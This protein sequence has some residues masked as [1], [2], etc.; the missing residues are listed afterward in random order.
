[1]LRNK[2][3][4]IVAIALVLV[5]SGGGYYYYNNVYLQA[6]EPIGEPTLATFV[7]SRGD[8]VIT[9]D[10]SGTLVPA[11]EMALGF[12]SGGVLAEVLVEVGDNV[13]AGQVLARLDDAE[14]QSQVDQAKISLRQAELNLAEL[15]QEVDPAGLASAQ[16]S[17]ASAKAE[18]TKLTS[19]PADQDLLAA[20]E[21]V[22]SAQEAL[23]DLLA[24]PDS[25]QVEIA[26]ADLTLAEINLRTAQA[27]YDKVAWKDNV[28]STK[29]AAD[30]WQATTN[31]DRAKA[32]HDEVRAGPAAD[33][34]SDARS[35]VAQAQAQLDAL[36]ED[37]DPN[38]IVAAEAKV[39]QAQAQLDDLLAGASAKDLE[40]AELNVAQAQLN[41]ESAQ[42]GLEDTL[43]VAPAPGTVVAA[44]AQ[45]GESVGTSAF[46]T[47]ADLEEPQVLFWVEES[48]LMSVAPGNRVNIVFEA[49]PDY[50]FPG[51]ILSVDPALVTVDGTS[52]VQS[53]A[54]V[55]VSHQRGSAPPVRLLSGMNAEVEIVAGQALN[56]VLVPIQALRDLGP[57]QYAV[58]VVQSNGELELRPVAVGLKD[59]VHAEILS[60][61]EPGQVIST[62]TVES[63]DTSTTPATSD[64]QPPPGIMRL[65]GGG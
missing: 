40:T 2:L 11:S 38:E 14:A 19:P 57:E 39:A 53:W 8:L 25:E 22:K 35:R 7:V 15:A 17:L 5:A 56:A 10:G 44:E 29:E 3:F 33:E 60:G 63:T 46:I 9:A 59:F 12:R 4:W 32:E 62:G 26:K 28:G 51:E 21:N 61:L 58:F 20:Q 43:L 23:D 47:L 24:G 42:R 30:L 31:Y 6:Q 55:D 45:R 64:E 27:A 18:L 16:A 41:L 49:L 65:F 34:V 37:P 54:S 1:M 48:D 52:A 13:E 50:S 36:L